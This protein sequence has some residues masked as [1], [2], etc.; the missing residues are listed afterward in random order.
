MFY[1]FIWERVREKTRSREG[2]RKKQTP[3]EQGAGCQVWSQNPE[4]KRWAKGS[5]LTH[6]ATKVPDREGSYAKLKTSE[7]R[8]CADSCVKMGTVGSPLE[9]IY[10]FL[11]LGPLILYY[12]ELLFLLPFPSHTS[13]EL[14]SYMV[15]GPWPEWID[16]LSWAKLVSPK[17]SQTWH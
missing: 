17:E 14:Y 16:P 11:C 3:S 10:N 1:L 13:V 15:P 2:Q 8:Q 7:C 12:L 4:I 5:G 6:W 9:A